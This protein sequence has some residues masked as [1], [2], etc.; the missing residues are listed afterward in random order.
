MSGM[1]DLSKQTFTYLNLIIEI[2]EKGTNYQ[3]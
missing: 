3:S 1:L 2:L